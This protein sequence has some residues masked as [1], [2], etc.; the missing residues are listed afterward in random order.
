MT[1]ALTQMTSILKRLDD[2]VSK[3]DT[4]DQP[5]RD[6]DRRDHRDS[7]RHHHRQNGPPLQ[8]SISGGEGSQPS[9]R[10]VTFDT[11]ANETHGSPAAPPQHC[12]YCNR[13]GH[14]EDR[15]FKKR[16]DQRAHHHQGQHNQENG[17]IAQPESSPSPCEY[18]SAFM[19]AAQSAP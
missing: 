6:S 16:D 8:G 7:H 17:Y 15:C 19:A 18:P 4:R 9:N 2:K 14:S 13:P 12:T 3:L 11:L 10:R 1:K 5:R